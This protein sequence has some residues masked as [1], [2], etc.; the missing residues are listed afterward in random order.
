MECD[1][2]SHASRARGHRAAAHGLHADG[3]ERHAARGTERDP[4]TWDLTND[5]P[6]IG[7]DLGET[8]ARSYYG[9][10]PQTTG[11]NGYWATDLALNTAVWSEDGRRTL[12]L[13]CT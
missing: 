9:G 7:L 5:K 1:G 4:T 8:F 3:A 10:A 6:T 2:C 12:I 13:R 11:T